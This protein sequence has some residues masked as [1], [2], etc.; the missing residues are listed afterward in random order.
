[1]LSL[2]SWNLGIILVFGL[3]EKKTIKMCVDIAHTRLTSSQQSSKQK[4]FSETGV[5]LNCVQKVSSCLRENTVRLHYKPNHVVLFSV[6][7][8]ACCEILTKHVLTCNVWK[9]ADS[10]S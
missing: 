10:M 4:F 8:T 5:N 6:I 7:N 1:M 2:A 3:R 9:N